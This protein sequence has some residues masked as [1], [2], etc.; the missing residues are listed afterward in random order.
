MCQASEDSPAP[1]SATPAP[2]ARAVAASRRKN[3]AAS[4]IEMPSRP[5]SYGRHGCGD[6]S[7]SELNP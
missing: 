1:R 4:P 5:V 2:F 7:S 3:A 6:S